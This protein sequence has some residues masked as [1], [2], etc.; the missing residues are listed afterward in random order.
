MH[1]MEAPSCDRVDE[2]QGVEVVVELVA[3]VC[4]ELGD[5]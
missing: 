1:A 3:S 5:V 4:E 2:D